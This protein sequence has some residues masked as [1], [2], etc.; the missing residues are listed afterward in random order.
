MNNKENTRKIIHF[1]AGGY[2]SYLAFQL[3]SDVFTEIEDTTF[4]VVFFL[5]A[6]IFLIVGFLLMFSVLRSEFKK[7]KDKKREEMEALEEHTEP[8][9]EITDSE[10]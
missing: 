2:L 5:F 1:L 4:R 10:E 8:N 6:A 7:I 9:T 3:F